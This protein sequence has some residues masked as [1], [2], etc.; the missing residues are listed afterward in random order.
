M[1]SSFLLYLLSIGLL[2]QTSTAQQKGA[3]KQPRGTQVGS[4]EIHPDRSVTFSV[5]A[6]KASHVVLTGE[7]ASGPQAMQKDSQGL[8]TP[9]DSRRSHLDRVAQVLNEVAPLLWQ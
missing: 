5:A 6:P 3:A 8:W 1:R 7:F 2:T 9:H 4:P